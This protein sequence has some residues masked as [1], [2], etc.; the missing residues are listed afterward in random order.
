[1]TD[2]DQY[3]RFVDEL[4]ESR[5]AP[6]WKAQ[7]DRPILAKMEDL[8]MTLSDEDQEKVEAESRRA[9]PDW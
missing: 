7:D 4:R 2:F 3:L 5:K 6:T 1:M 8:Y 9:W